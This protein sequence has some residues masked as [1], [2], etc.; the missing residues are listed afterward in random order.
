[1]FF[2]TKGKY[3][4]PRRRIDIYEINGFDKQQIWAIFRKYHYLNTQFAKPAKQYVGIMDDKIVCHSGVIQAPLRKG[5]KQVHRLVVLPDYQGIGIGTRFISFI[6][7]LYLC[8][9]YILKLITTTPAI[10]FALDKSELWKLTRS[11]HVQK[12]GN[13]KYMTH[14]SKSESSKRM[15]YTY[16]YV[17][18]ENNELKRKTM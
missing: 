16:Q 14:W 4:T 3:V 7:E 17:G 12:S 8:S 2:W 18:K 10:R 6:A 1:M 5:Y 9:D 15:T 11:G 13:T